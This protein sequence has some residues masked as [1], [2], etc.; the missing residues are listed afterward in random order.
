MFKKYYDMFALI[1]AVVFA[2][3]SK[4]ESCQLEYDNGNGEIE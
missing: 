2:L 4:E 3:S 1:V